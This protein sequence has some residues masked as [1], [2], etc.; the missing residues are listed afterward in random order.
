MQAQKLDSLIGKIARINADGSIPKDN[1]FVGK[2][3]RAPGDLVDRPSQRA[4]GHAASDD[5]RA[6]GSGA[7]HARRRRDNIAQKGRTT[8]GRRSRTASSTRADRS[9]AASRQGGHGTAAL[10]LGSDH[11]A[12]RHD[13]LHGPLFPAWKGSLFIGGLEGT[14][15]RTADRRGRPDRRRGA[16]ALG[17]QGTLPRRVHGP[18]GALYVLTDNAKGR[19]LKLVP[20]RQTAV[21]RLVAPWS[22]NQVDTMASPD[23]DGAG[24]S[25]APDPGRARR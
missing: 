10:L 4:G 1:P 6:V 24:A 17:S 9:P 13:V 7:R 12:E 16:V 18:D 15:A 25:R 23:R 2:H 8:A 11:R 20:R 5:R 3:G 22:L 19:L 21:G 14:H